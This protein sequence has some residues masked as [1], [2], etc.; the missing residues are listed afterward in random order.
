[1]SPSVFS[2]Q[3]EAAKPA[4][5][6]PCVVSLRTSRAAL[7]NAPMV[8]ETASLCGFWVN[9]P[10]RKNASNDCPDIAVLLPSH[11]E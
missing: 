6:A 3:R 8:A 9:D 1:M 7:A 5:S 10:E 11:N 2:L 4:L